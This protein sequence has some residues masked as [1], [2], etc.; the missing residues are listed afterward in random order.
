M[1]DKTAV[2]SG[3]LMALATLLLMIGAGL[4]AW[5]TQRLLSDETPN[6][7]GKYDPDAM[8]AEDFDCYVSAGLFMYNHQAGTCGDLDDLPAGRKATTTTEEKLRESYYS[9]FSVTS[10]ACLDLDDPEFIEQPGRIETPT[11]PT[12]VQ[13]Y[14]PDNYGEISYICNTARATQA[15]SVL[16]ILIAIPATLIPFLVGCCGKNCYSLGSFLCFMVFVCGIATVF[17]YEKFGMEILSDLNS[18]TASDFRRWADGN[19]IYDTAISTA[20]GT[21]YGPGYGSEVAG[22]FF[23]GWAALLLLVGGKAPKNT[24]TSGNTNKSGTPANTAV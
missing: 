18:G 20:Y 14:S 10:R 4:P 17:M 13:R 3:A 9:Q 15:F 19:D 16:A 7:D 6:T 24:D 8:Y 1:Y 12:P 11:P 22:I 5:T 23:T 2:F 21:N